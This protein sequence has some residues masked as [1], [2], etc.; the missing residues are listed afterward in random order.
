MDRERAKELLPIIEAFINGEEVEQ[1]WLPPYETSDWFLC[2]KHINLDACIAHRLRPKPREFWVT[3]NE[4]SPNVVAHL[5]V[6]KEPKDEEKQYW[7][8]VREVIE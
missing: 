8:H 2:T 3:P 5:A 4:P 7:I 1:R 6:P